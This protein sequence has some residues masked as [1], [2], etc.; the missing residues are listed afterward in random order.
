MPVDHNTSIPDEQQGEGMKQA[1]AK[2]ENVKAVACYTL[3]Y[4]SARLRE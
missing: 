4:T 2:K 1:R 3:A